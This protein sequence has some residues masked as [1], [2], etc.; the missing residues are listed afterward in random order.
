ML[1]SVVKSVPDQREAVKAALDVIRPICGSRKPGVALI[2]G[3]GFG[4]FASQ[5]E[6][7]VS[8]PYSD[9]PGFPVSRVTGHAGKF[10]IGHLRGKEVIVMQG[11]GHLYE[12][13]S[14]QELSLPVRV[15]RNLGAEMLVVTNAAGSVNPSLE[16]GSLML[17]S[18]HM[19]FTQ[20]NP[21]I[22]PNDDHTGTRFPDSARVYDTS[23]QEKAMQIARNNG[24]TLP[25]GVYMFM[26]GPS[27]ETPSEVRM[28]GIL[29]AD[30]VGMSTFPEAL[31]AF[32]CGMKVLGISY[33]SNAG[34]GLQQE[35]LDHAKVL[36]MSAQTQNHFAQLCN[37]LI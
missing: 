2:L 28:A 31:T 6:N 21:L 20:I 17:I 16:V 13:Y 26:T 12:G 3:S 11:R 19:N 10:I 15:I 36:Q 7:K 9:I 5:L 25:Q 35:K 8:I 22:G 32:H 4:E 27:F 30:V 23:L 29:G 24:W 33:I 37:E 1:K 18:D 14:I 34:A